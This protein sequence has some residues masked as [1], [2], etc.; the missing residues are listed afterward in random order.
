[1]KFLCRFRKVYITPLNFSGAYPIAFAIYVIAFSIYTC[2]TH[3]LS[4]GFPKLD[5]VS[6]LANKEKSKLN[7]EKKLPLVRIEPRTS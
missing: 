4:R 6:N 5:K 2:N 3:V 1:M 7:S